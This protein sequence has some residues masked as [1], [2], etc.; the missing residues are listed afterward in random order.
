MASKKNAN[1]LRIE[2][3]Q[4]IKQI[5]LGHRLSSTLK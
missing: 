4:K 2:E 1:Q 5:P 3:C